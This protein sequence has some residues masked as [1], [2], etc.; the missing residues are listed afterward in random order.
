MH[1]HSALQAIADYVTTRLAR[2]FPGQAVLGVIN[3]RAGT[4]SRHRMVQRVV[5]ELSATV[6]Q[7]PRAVESG[8]DVTTVWTESVEGLHGVVR[9]WY[10]RNSQTKRKPPILV[11][12]GGDGTHNQVMRALEV[13]GDRVWY[14]RVP[15]GSG[16]D[17]VEMESLGQLLLA[18]EEKP[19]P[20]WIPEV[21]VQTP[22]QSFRA[23]NI[24][25][26]G[27]DAFVTM[28]HQQLRR[29]LPG[30][31]YRII[32]NAAVLIFER[33]VGLG[34]TSITTPEEDLGCAERVLIA[35]G[36]TGRRTYG[37][38]IRILPGDENLC[39]LGSA[40]LRNK[41]RL[42]KL[43]FAG[44]HVFDPIATMRRTESVT[45]DYDGRLPMQV[46]G[47]ATWLESEDFPLTMRIH[48]RALLVVEPTFRG[49]PETHT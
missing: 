45:I 1:Y 13:A 6:P 9:D 40:S 26:V 28:K 14:F 43:L 21:R 12:L 44:D 19:I 24:T 18:L 20:K 22:R 27:I 11:S 4:V 3:G 10:R 34:P 35:M 41:L 23:F 30:N 25:S 31:T 15:L 8:S 16:N 5:E 39:I 37:D 42:K 49:F 7:W 33:L 2:H 46:D 48:P 47:E 36:V 17:A 38:H 32:A 29:V